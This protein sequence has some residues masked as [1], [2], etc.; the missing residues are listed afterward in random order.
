MLLRRG[1]RTEIKN[2]TQLA[3]Q[4]KSVASQKCEEAEIE[5]RV[6]N[7]GLSVWSSEEQYGLA[8]VDDPGAIW[9]PMPL[10]FTLPPGT[11][12]APNEL[13]TFTATLRTP[14]DFGL[15]NLQVQM[16]R[17]SADPFGQTGSLTIQVNPRISTDA[18]QAWWLF[19]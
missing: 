4:S 9:E 11:N 5:I 8:V 3:Y 6:R 2:G 15:Y 17:D 19:D 10:Q 13:Y 16:A 14:R 1:Q 18:T 7:V 12:V